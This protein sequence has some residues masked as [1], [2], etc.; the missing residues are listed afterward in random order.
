M[1]GTGWNDRRAG[2]SSR[3]C[4]FQ[5]MPESAKLSGKGDVDLSSGIR[6]RETLLSRRL[7]SETVL[8]DLESGRYYGL[9]ETG[10]SI[11]NRLVEGQCL[12]QVHSEL[13]AELDVQSE[14]LERDLVTFVRNLVERRLVVLHV[15]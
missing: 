7:G 10:T 12:R 3:L 8:L 13:L 4:S 9:D 15:A 5:K 2:D 14:R 1:S 6:T 11:W